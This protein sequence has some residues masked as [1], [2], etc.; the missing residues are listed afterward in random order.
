M[1]VNTNLAVVPVRLNDHS[2]AH[3]LLSKET[4]S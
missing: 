1:T 3:T 4:P 2:L